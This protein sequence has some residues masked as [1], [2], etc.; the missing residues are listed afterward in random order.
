MGCDSLFEP[1]LDG[2][3][4]RLTRL[5]RARGLPFGFG[6]LAR[7]SRSDLP[8]HPERILAEQVRLGASIGLLGRSFREGLQPADLDSEV[9][10]L[11][12]AIASLR[13]Q[14]GASFAGNRA[15]M[16]AEVDQW[17]RRTAGSRLPTVP[18]HLGS[19]QTSRELLGPR[20]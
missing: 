1:I 19:Q 7:L 9:A 15:A 17:R 3:V 11:R 20:V 6:G 14:D 8:V 16:R 18:A 4:D 10:R 2:T 12:G 13:E 5:I